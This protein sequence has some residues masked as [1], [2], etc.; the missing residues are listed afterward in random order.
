[1]KKGAAIMIRR[2]FFNGLMLLPFFPEFNMRKAGDF[3]PAFPDYRSILAGY[4]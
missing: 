2:F 4:G 1:M 3:S